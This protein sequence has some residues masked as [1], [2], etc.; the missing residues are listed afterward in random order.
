MS[1]AA[2]GIL[3]WLSAH[4]VAMR[5]LLADLVT[6]DSGTHDIAGVTAVGSRLAAFFE[7][8]GIAVTRLEG[9]GFGSGL[10][11]RI[12]GS[13]AAAPVLLM[14]HLD[15][16]FPAGEAARRPFRIDTGR[17]Y[18][19]GVADMKAG[20][21]MN[22]FVLAALH[23]CGDSEQ[24]V[25]VLFTGDEEIGSPGYR[26]VIEAAA[27]ET[28]FAFNAEPGRANGNLVIERRGGTFMRLTVHG[29]AAH[30]GVNLREGVNAIA[31]LAHKIVALHSLTDFEAGLTVNVG[32]VAGGQ[33]V[34]TTA[35]RAEALVD[36][37]FGSSAA[38]DAAFAQI[39]VIQ[40]HGRV[41]GA[42]ATLEITGEF[43]P[44]VPAPT[45]I[46]LLN[47]Y[48]SAADELGF[49]VEGEAT[50]GCADSGAAA[51]AGAATLCGTGPVGGGAHTAEEYIELPSLLTRAQALALTIQRLP[52]RAGD[53]LLPPSREG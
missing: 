4:E 28:A 29:R 53:L 35:P 22:S 11:A 14:G 13:G 17:A 26:P 9:G 50:G 45:T 23:A 8:Q 15:T 38:R 39:E 27:R 49:S 32:V 16:V 20:L 47:L 3:G 18:G 51:T 48:K 6:I 33:S 42:S 1:G 25:T 21:V 36:L 37:R 46:A 10:R 43:L 19:P 44:L 40:A 7:A 31:E 41:P 30:S 12:D 24:A 2:K 5:E 52:A 34:N